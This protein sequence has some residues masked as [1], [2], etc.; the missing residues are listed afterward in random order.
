MSREGLQFSDARL[1]GASAGRGPC[2][3]TVADD[4]P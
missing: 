2:T 4:L 3:I 1:P